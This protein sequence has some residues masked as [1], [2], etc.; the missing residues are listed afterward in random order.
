VFIGPIATSN[1]LVKN[2]LKRDEL[3]DRFGVKAVEMEGSGIADATWT[4]E[5]G[6]LVV[7]GICDYA[8]ARKS[9]KWQDYAAIVAAAYTRGLIET[10]PAAST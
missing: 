3:R 9:D 1:A 8:D 10:L 7:R 5:V 2:P 6:Y 4:A